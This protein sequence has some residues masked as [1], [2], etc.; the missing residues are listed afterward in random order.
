MP[1]NENV[2]AKAKVSDNDVADSGA[3]ALAVEVLVAVG[4]T[5]AAEAST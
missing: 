4:L 3:E 2:N 5:E 1:N